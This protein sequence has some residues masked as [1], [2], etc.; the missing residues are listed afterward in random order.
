ML[1][2]RAFVIAGLVAAVVA[3]PTAGANKVLWG[4]H[5]VWCDGVVPLAACN[6]CQVPWHEFMDPGPAMCYEHC[7][8]C[9]G[10]GTEPPKD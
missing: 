5:P 4:Y 8:D 1:V 10:P 9:W 7:P 3:A 6:A 2:V